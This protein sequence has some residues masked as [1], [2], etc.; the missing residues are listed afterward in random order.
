MASA[1]AHIL[2]VFFHICQMELLSGL[3]VCLG[4]IFVNMVTVEKE[5]I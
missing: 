3:F 2:A 4:I 5:L 1:L